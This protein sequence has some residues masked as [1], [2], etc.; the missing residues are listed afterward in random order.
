MNQY[1][2]L[3]LSWDK[4]VDLW[5]NFFQLLF[6]NWKELNQKVYLTTNNLTYRD[7]RVYSVQSGEDSSVFE[8]LKR[9]ID[10]IEEEYILFLIDDLYFI[11]PIKASEINNAIEYAIAQD[12]DYYNFSKQRKTKAGRYSNSNY[13]N[14]IDEREN[15]GICINLALFKKSFLLHLLSFCDGNV[16]KIEEFFKYI[17]NE[18]R[19]LLGNPLLLQDERKL[20][21]HIA[22]VSKG[23]FN[24][25]EYAI[26]KKKG[27]NFD[28][29]GREVLSVQQETLRKIKWFGRTI[30]PNHYQKNVKKLCGHFGIKF[31]TDN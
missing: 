3:V 13:A 25:K 22:L 5:D 21:N 12:C 8:R 31:T 11:N 17:D 15:Y 2:L 19:E 7:E 29:K 10:V 28:I 16:W 18:K 23:K 1:A 20:F 30:I 27:I 26:C 9:A 14:I 24:R 6:K 4:D